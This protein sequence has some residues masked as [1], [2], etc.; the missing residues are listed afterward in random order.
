LSRQNVWASSFAGVVCLQNKPIPTRGK[1]A[2]GAASAF[3]RTALIACPTLAANELL[4]IVVATRE[5][6]NDPGQTPNPHGNRTAIVT[7]KLAESA[8]SLDHSARHLE[9]CVAADVVTVRPPQIGNHAIW[10][11]IRPLVW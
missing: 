4:E 10:E 11:R 7:A 3:A 2:H 1:R 6:T 9:R 8:V 5:P